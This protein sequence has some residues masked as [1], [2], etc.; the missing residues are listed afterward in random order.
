MQTLS[1]KNQIRNDYPSGIFLMFPPILW[2]LWA[3]QHFFGFLP[4]RNFR[5]VTEMDPTSSYWFMIIAFILSIVFI[6]LFIFR[7]RKFL[8]LCKLGIIV[9]ATITHI[10]FYK[11]RGRIDFKFSYQNSEY[12]TGNPIFKTKFT[13]LFSTNDSVE[14]LLLPDIPKKAYILG[15][16]TK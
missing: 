15:I 14:V 7:T 1:I 6:T 10:N 13:K 16:F 11:D 4:K 5:G 12:K 3:F 9:T 8:K 2:V